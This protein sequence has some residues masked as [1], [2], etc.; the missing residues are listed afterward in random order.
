MCDTP[1]KEQ[2]L[3][4]NKHQ[5]EAKYS[6]SDEE[7]NSPDT[8]RK[9]ISTEQSFQAEEGSLSDGAV[10][11]IP[12]DSTISFR[13]SSLLTLPSRPAILL[14]DILTKIIN[15]RCQVCK[16]ELYYNRHEFRKQG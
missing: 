11:I 1:G 16:R 10:A 5:G 7:P 9:S 6:I 13:L 4:G 3:D 15:R 2:L 14:S 8:T 12:R